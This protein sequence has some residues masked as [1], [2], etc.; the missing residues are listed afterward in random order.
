MNLNGMLYRDKPLFGL[1]I[2]HATI[3]AMQI[4]KSIGQ[5]PTVS[6]YGISGFAP[7]AIQNGVIIKPEVI[8]QAV[9]QLF[10]KNLVG[11]IS[12]N[13][14][15]CSLPTAHTFSRPMRIPPMDHHDIV[16]AIRLEAEQYIP[17]PLDSL[18][19]DYEILH[20]DTQGIELSMVAAPKK[21][22]DSYLATLQS[23]QLEPVA[24]EPSINATSRLIQ[25]AISTGSEP[26]ILVDIGSVTTDIAIFDKTLLV[27]STLSS[28]G[29][30]VTNA[31]EHS[32]HLTYA[33][34]AD[35]KNQYGIAYSDRQQRVVD[36]IKPQLETLVR[37]IQK[38]LRYYSERAAKS[39]HKIAQVIMVGG[40]A[41]MPGL[42]HYLAKE[43]R[44]PAHNLEPWERI[45]FGQLPIPDPTDSSMYITVAGEAILDPA[46]VTK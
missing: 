19:V 5:A 37:E 39:Q 12:S 35:L 9:H 38:S 7:D 27:A 21:I 13:R 31:I 24:F 15:A 34:A 17:L 40:G 44:L 28:G 6:G 20:Q 11:T 18:Y 45:N 26:S 2:G 46:E 4:D 1:D 23:L 41:I 10:E 29:D 33:Q 16:E 43:L 3:K 42:D 8:A 30:S 32:L 22:I 14:V 25:M 36:A